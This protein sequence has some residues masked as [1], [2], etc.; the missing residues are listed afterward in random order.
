MSIFLSLAFKYTGTKI[1]KIVAIIPPK[2]RILIKAFGINT[3]KIAG[4]PMTIKAI[5]DFCF[6]KAV[7]RSALI[8]P[9][10]VPAADVKTAK[11]E[12]SFKIVA[13]NSN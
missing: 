9:I 13:S 8:R 1:T 3:V 10:P 7:S 4:S 11:R 2:E 12:R 6:P 5:N